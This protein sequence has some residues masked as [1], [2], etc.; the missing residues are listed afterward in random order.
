MASDNL[1]HKENI[2]YYYKQYNHYF[3]KIHEY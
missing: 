1:I 2:Y 3:I